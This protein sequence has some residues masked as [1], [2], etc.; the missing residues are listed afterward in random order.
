MMRNWIPATTLI[1][2]TLSVHF[3]LGLDL[4]EELKKSGGGEDDAFQV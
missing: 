2:L 3:P 1:S 4:E